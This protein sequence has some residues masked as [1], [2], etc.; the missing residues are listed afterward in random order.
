MN[1]SFAVF[2]ILLFGL[3]SHA[4]AQSFCRETRISHQVAS[5]AGTLEKYVYKQYRSEKGKDKQLSIGLMRPL[6]NLPDKKRPLIIGV[7]GGAFVDFCPFEPCYVKYS[8]N[9]LTPNFTP[10]GFITTSVQYR[11]TSPLDYKS[12]KVKDDKLLETHYKAAQDVREAIKFI[13]EN[14]DRFGV[15]RENVFLVGTSAGAITVLHSAF[16]DEEEIPKNLLEKHGG[17][18]KREKIKGVISFSGAIYDLSYLAGDDKVPVM[19]V[20][21]T[22]DDI[23]PFEKGFYL[24]MTHLTPVYGGKA[25]FEEAKKQ[26]IPAQGFFYDFGHG[27]PDKFLSGIFKNANDFIRLNLNCPN[28]SPLNILAK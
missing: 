9:V 5:S 6:D 7:H 2:L 22:R 19:L 3:N 15:D 11:L 10:Q 25:I 28:R 8:E 24:R 16:M 26:G 13:F 17:L 21:G 27:Y 14:A 1:K 12:F 23:V 20:H 18:A 4:F